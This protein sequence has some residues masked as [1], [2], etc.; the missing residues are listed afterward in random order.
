MDIKDLARVLYAPHKAF[1]SIV[2]KPSYIGPIIVLIIFAIAFATSQYATQQRWYVEDTMPTKDQGDIWT[3]NAVYWSASPGTTVSNNTSTF[4]AS[5]STQFGTYYGNTSIQFNNS[6]TND[7]WMQIANDFNLNC[8]S[9]GFRNV[10]LRV[11]IVS[12][13]IAVQN[14]TMTLLSGSGN[15]SFSRD[16]TSIFSNG[17]TSVWYNLTIPLNTTDWT[18]IGTPNWD[19]ITGLKME[20]VWQ[21]ASNVSV[22]FDALYFRGEYISYGNSQGAFLFLGNAL[23]GVVQIVFEWILIAALMYI[24]LRALKVKSVWK[25]LFISVGFAL[26]TLV[27]QYIVLGIVVAL[28]YPNLYYPIEYLAQVPVE[29]QIIAQGLN[30]QLAFISQISVAIQVVFLVWLAGVG[31]FVVRANSNIIPSTATA[32]PYQPSE[33]PSTAPQEPQA[34]EELSWGKCIAISATSL[35]LTII[36]LGILSSIGFL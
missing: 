16:L 22:I 27:I 19:S 7:V 10:S 12:P 4:I 17:T 3:E 35:L 8:T 24:L 18:S 30:N 21:N 9:A 5:G 31:T 14:V 33:T 36:I 28:A 20:F 6:N 13:N 26:I 1:K 25:P 32:L 34:T 11:Q 23:N 29:S 2:K 15:S